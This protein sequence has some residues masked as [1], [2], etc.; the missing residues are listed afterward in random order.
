MNPIEFIN[1]TKVL[2]PN[3][4]QKEIDGKQVGTLPIFTDGDQVISCWRL[5]FRERIK[6]L[7]FGKIWLGIYSGQTQPPVWLSCDENVFTG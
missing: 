5:S 6:A 7:W 2:Q 4:N 3:S 1:Q